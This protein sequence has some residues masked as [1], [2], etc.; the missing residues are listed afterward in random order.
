MYTLQWVGVTDPDMLRRVFHSQQV[1]P[2]GFNRIYYSHPEVDR[3][4]DLATS[5]LTDDERLKYYSDV[6]KLVA[7]DAPYISLWYKT[8]VAVAQHE[9]TGVRL[10]PLAGFTFLK[11]VSWR[12][13][14][15]R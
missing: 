1:P 9:L 11:D 4:I 7:A 12:Q 5:A 8:N 13:M 14:T 10:S 2:V 6:Q 3:R 15:A